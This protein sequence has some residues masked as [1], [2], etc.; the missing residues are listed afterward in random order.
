MAAFNVTSEDSTPLITYAPVGAWNDSPDGDLFNQSYSGQSWHTT[1]TQGAT[2]TITFNGTGIWLF[3]AQRPNYGTYSISIDGQQTTGNAGAQ[4]PSFQQLLGGQ[5]GLPMGSH[6]V[7]FTNTGSQT[8]LDL[9]SLIFETQV[10]PSGATVS[11]DTVDDSDPAVQYLPSSTTWQINPLANT[12]QDG[13]HFTSDGGAQAQLK[14]NG[15]AVAIYGSVS[16]D[17]ANYT[18]AVDGQSQN[19]DGGSGGAARL[20]HLQTLLYFSNNFGPGEHTLLLTANPNEAGQKNT[21]QFMDIDAFTVYSTTGGSTGNVAPSAATPS[22]PASTS[23]STS[24]AQSSTSAAGQTI[25]SGS[26]I[27]TGII[28]GAIFAAIVGLLLIFLLLFVLLRRRRRSMGGPAPRVPSFKAGKRSMPTSPD[29]P[30]QR[31]D[32]MEA[33]FAGFKPNEKQAYDSSYGYAARSTSVNSYASADM[34]ATP[35]TSVLRDSYADDSGDSIQVRSDRWSNVP[36]R[37]PPRPPSLRMPRA[38]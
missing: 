38:M 18:V 27:S 26:S 33:G 20:L 19:F 30:I 36:L 34:P 31:P 5:S 6:T 9:D 3:G 1:S 21:G 13:L 2:A 11:Q 32:F 4:N 7:V 35:R 15:D 37:Q 10:G 24:G 8:S 22:E 29:L 28:A 12:I 16:P 25:T 17:H 23:N 14:F